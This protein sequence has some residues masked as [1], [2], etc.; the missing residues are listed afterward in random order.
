M[1]DPDTAAPGP[2]P[3][4]TSPHARH[5]GGRD[6]RAERNVTVIT[7]WIG[8]AAAD[9]GDAPYLQDAA[10]AGT[11]TYAG[12]R[13]STQ[14]W[15]R[16][17]DRAG[18]P[19]GARVAVHLPDP[20]GYATALVS[21]LG[22]GRVVVPLDPAAPAAEVARVLAVA[23][24]E[25]AVGDSG[26]GLPPGLA[27]LSP[28]DVPDRPDGP[29]GPGACPDTEHAV[30]PAG[31]SGGAEGSTC[32]RAGPPGRPRASCCARISWPMSPPPWPATTG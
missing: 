30:S 2:G 10:G 11:L 31:A 20:L 27:V 21:I 15:A 28:P 12:L 22:A 16:C 5:A 19:P 24:P 7:D 32:A 23:R 14:A 3:N 6:R 29:N 4:G 1:V 26:G 17:L 13:R 8:Q 9:R 18:L 25:A